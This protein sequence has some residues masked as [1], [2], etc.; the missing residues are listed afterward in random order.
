MTQ[1]ARDIKKSP[2]KKEKLHFL[3]EENY[4]LRLVSRVIFLKT[5]LLDHLALQ[6][7]E[8]LQ[9]HKRFKTSTRFYVYTKYSF[10]I[11]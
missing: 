10:V 6:L 4:F 5:W 8:K 11:K 1:D 3:R 2:S 7:S 9:I